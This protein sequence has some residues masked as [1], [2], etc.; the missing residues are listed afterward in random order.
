MSVRYAELRSILEN[1]I[2][3]P[4]P[5]SAPTAITQR[6]PIFSTSCEP[7]PAPSTMPALNGRNARPVFIGLYCLKSC[8]YSVMNKNSANMPAPISRPTR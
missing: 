3:P 1:Q 6:G 2:M 5:S 7:S 8:R 4:T